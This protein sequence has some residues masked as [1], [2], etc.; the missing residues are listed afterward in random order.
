MDNDALATQ[1][2]AL[3]DDLHA[4]I[5]ALEEGA[6]KARALRLANVAH[7]ALEA[8]RDHAAD[9]GLVQ[10]FSGGDPKP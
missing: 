8:L 1:F 5:A 3:M 2:R 9:N 4:R 6:V 7:G 10:P